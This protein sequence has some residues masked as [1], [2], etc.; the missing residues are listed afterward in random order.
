MPEPEPLRKVASGVSGL[1]EITGGGLPFHRSTLICGGAGSGKTLFALTYILEGARKDLRALHGGDKAMHAQ[2]R[3][4]FSQPTVD[5]AAAEALRQKML[6][7]HDQASKRMMQAMLD[8]SRVLSAEQRGQL[9]A[10]SAAMRGG[11][12]GD[13]EHEWHGHGGPDGPG[14]PGEGGPEH[15]WRPHGAASGNAD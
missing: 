11:W 13:H 14:R 8:L 3:Q 9:M 7:Q 5:P 12:R 4:L 6:A 10:I 1:D 2:L 15:G